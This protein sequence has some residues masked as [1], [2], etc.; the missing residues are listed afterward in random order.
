MIVGN[1]NQLFGNLSD[2]F[3]PLDKFV[4]FFIVIKIIV[5]F[6]SAGA[7]F[8]PCVEIPSVKAEIASRVTSL[9]V[10]PPHFFLQGTIRQVINET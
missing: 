2:S 8:K 10:G 4:N 5:F 9:S 1:D 7:L 6:V 3:Y